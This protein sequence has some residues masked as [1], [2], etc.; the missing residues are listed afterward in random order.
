MLKVDLKLLAKL[1]GSIGGA[2]LNTN[3]IGVA[4]PALAFTVLA[5]GLA[6]GFGLEALGK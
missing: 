6:I 1:L 4:N 3:I 2:L 5:V